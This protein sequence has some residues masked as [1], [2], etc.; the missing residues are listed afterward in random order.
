MQEDLNVEIA[1]PIVEREGPRTSMVGPP[2]RGW[3]RIV[4][5]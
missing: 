3:E 4:E 5:T 1:A 2:S